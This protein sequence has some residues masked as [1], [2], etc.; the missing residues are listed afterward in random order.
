MLCY[1]YGGQYDSGWCLA[2]PSYSSMS[3]NY[4]ER[5]LFQR[6]KALI[7]FTG[8]PTRKPGQVEWD[9]NAFLYGLFRRG[10][11]TVFRSRKYG[12]VVQPATPE[13]IGLQFEP[14][15]MIV[16][17]PY[18][19]FDRP[20]RIGVECENIMLTPDY[21]GI[22]DI[23][24]KYAEELKYN[25]VAIRLSAI[26]ARFAYAIAV[27]DDKSAATV[28]AIMEKLENG[29]PGITYHA[30]LKENLMLAEGEAPWTQFDRDLKKNFIYPELL[31]ARR[32]ILTDFYRELGV[33][34]SPDKKERMV[35][36]EA[37]AYQAETFNRRQVWELSLRDSIDRVNRLTGLS[38]NFKWNEM[39]VETNAAISEPTGKSAEPTKRDR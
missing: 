32:T 37:E 17:T 13:G 11:L 27:A 33:Q 12:F 10:F 19:S 7:T 35:Q 39:E 30:K 4:W 21:T 2:S 20:L 22:W 16:A 15:G 3:Q 23:I 8:L 29:E 28:K 31:Q 1:N 36:V 5:S 24:S 18:F 25:D 38:I 26:N 14:T 6:C 9:M 34:S